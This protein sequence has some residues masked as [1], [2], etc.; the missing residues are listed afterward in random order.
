M[1][2]KPIAATILKTRSGNKMANHLKRNQ[3]FYQHSSPQVKPL[4]KKL[5][6]Q[7]TNLLSKSR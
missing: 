7:P 5:A 2:C 3:S 1:V 6:G 4:D